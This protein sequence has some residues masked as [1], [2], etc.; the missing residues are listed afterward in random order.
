MSA[1]RSSVGAVSDETKRT[2]DEATTVVA[3]ARAEADARKLECLDAVAIGIPAAVE[4]LA[5][6]TAQAQPDVTRA[7]GA[8][9]VK[10]LRQDL[11]AEAAELA[12][13]VRTASEK[14]KWPARDSEWSRVEP[15][16]IH[17][18]LFKFMYG[19]PVDRVGNV[20]GRHGYDVRKSD[21]SGSQGLVLPQSLYDEASFEHVAEALNELGAA[22]IALAKAKADDDKEVI[23]S[24]WDET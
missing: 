5:K 10:A 14:I 6:S 24:L 17:S 23:D 18:A 8:P 21:R 3:A 7:L 20:F 2:L 15:R 19:A 11:A 13:L 22:E 4:R 9:G 16:K 12:D 1:L